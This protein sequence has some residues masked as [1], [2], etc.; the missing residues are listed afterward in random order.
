M[1]EKEITFT[2]TVSNEC[3][4]DKEAIIAGLEFLT[5]LL[6]GADGD[7]KYTSEVLELLDTVKIDGKPADDVLK[8]AIE[9]HKDV[10]LRRW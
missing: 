9:E 4:G 6:N 3:Q 7:I 5:F 2:F 8:K 10:K 1:S